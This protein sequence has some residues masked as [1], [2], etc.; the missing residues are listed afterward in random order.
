MAVKLAMN[1]PKGPFEWQNQ[2]AAGAAKT[3]T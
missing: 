1:F 3:T 2:S